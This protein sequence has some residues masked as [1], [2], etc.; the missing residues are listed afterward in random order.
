MGEPEK[1]KAGEEP[2]ES[3]ADLQDA[4]AELFDGGGGEAAAS[5]KSA[6]ITYLCA[7]CD[8]VFSGNRQVK[9]CSKCGSPVNRYSKPAAQKSV[10]LVDDAA[11]ARKKIG[12]ILKSMGCKVVEAA[13]GLE[14]LKLAEDVEPD[15]IVLDVQMPRMGGLEALAE[16]RRDERFASIPI[17]MM[18]VVSDAETVSK[19]ITGDANDY[20]RKDSTVAEISER[21]KQHLPA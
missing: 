11:L 16:F 15:L 7:K 12:A 20:I 3:G 21:L 9:H 18:T 13:D 19:A 14:G 2:D 8:A 1:D 5:P 6:E 4:A 17:V 10:L